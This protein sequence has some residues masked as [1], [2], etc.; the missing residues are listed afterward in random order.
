MN[1][2][3]YIEHFSDEQ[4]C[5]NYFKQVRIKAGIICK[6]CDSTKH[7][8]LEN[9]GVFECSKCR[10][11]TTLKSGTVMEN[12]RLPFKTWFFIFFLMTNTKKGLSACELQRQIGHKRYTTVWDIMLRI[13]KKMGQRDAIYQLKDMVEYDDAYFEKATN[14][15]QKQRLK[16]EKEVNDKPVLQLWQN[17]F[18]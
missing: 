1:L 7:Y 4:S 16:E 18:L 17:L 3:N 2:L 10:F 15:S 12:S 14:S 9:R 8:W 11:R 13:R 5:R 6:K